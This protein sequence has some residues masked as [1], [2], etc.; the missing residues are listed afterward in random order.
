MELRIN[1]VRINHSRPVFDCPIHWE[2]EKVK[3]IGELRRRAG[4]L[5]GVCEEF[6]SRALDRNFWTNCTIQDWK[7]HK[8]GTFLHS[9]IPGRCGRVVSAS[10]CQAGGLW[11]KSSILPLLKHA[12]GESDW[13]LCCRGVAPEVNLRERISCTSPQSS[14]KAEPTLALKPRG[15]VTRS[16]KQG[17]QWPHKWTF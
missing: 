9:S 3:I 14:N 11:F 8:E 5:V 17:Y 10:D 2:K 1:R 15:D 13:M 4:I 16:L 12:C 6:F 7:D